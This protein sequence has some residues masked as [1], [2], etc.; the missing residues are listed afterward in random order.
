MLTIADVAVAKWLNI[1]LY[2]V[3]SPKKHLEGEVRLALG[4]VALAD[5]WKA[6]IPMLINT[7]PEAA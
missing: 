1:A 5:S 2:S 3:E 7:G 4:S 6:S